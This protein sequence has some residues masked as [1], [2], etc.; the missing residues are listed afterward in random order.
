[1]LF[2]SLTTQAKGVQMSSREVTI[3]I[4]VILLF[5]AL[6]CYYAFFVADH[7]KYIIDN[8]PEGDPIYELLTDEVMEELMSGRSEINNNEGA[9]LVDETGTIAT[10]ESGKQANSPDSPSLYMPRNRS[11]SLGFWTMTP[12]IFD[13][14]INFRKGTLKLTVDY[15]KITYED[16]SL[17][18]STPLL[19][20]SCPR[21]RSKNCS[22]NLAEDG[23]TDTVLQ[24]KLLNDF[25]TQFRELRA[26]VK[27]AGTAAQKK[28]DEEEVRRKAAN[29]ACLRSRYA[30]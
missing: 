23:I 20:I 19:R 16:E 10:T 28:I 25:L 6:A 7:R 3:G 30:K 5:V 1:M 8:R 11:Y 9:I 26:E 14:P 27:I 24:Q 18:C 22:T 15:S 2:C 12:S 29:N 13:F 4:S 17:K 21:A